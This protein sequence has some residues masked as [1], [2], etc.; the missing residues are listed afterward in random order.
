MVNFRKI[1]EELSEILSPYNYYL[2]ELPLKDERGHKLDYLKNIYVTYAIKG[3]S[4]GIYKDVNDLEVQIITDAKNRIKA[5]E[6]AEEIN[7]KLNR[8]FLTG[9]RINKK[10]AWKVNFI[11][12]ENKENIV[13]QYDLNVY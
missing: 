2:D 10:N 7:E 13:L 8:K 12:E 4:D 6:L 5:F 9:A 3:A 1:L 11:D